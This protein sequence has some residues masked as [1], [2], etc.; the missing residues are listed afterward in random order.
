MHKI[1]QS[2]GFLGRLLRPLLKT[3]L[4]LMENVLKILAKSVLIPLGS[5]AVA[6]SAI[7]ATIH[8]KI[9]ESGRPSSLTKR[10]TL[11]TSK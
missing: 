7:V 10:K 5:T 1:A 4:P 2:E 11:I 3:G 6:A 9:F 8:K